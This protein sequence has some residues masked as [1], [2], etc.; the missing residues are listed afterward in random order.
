MLWTGVTPVGVEA[1]AGDR[2]GVELVPLLDGGSSR[3]K[4]P[5][6]G[7]SASGSV[8]PRAIPVGPTFAVVVDG[9]RSVWPVLVRIGGTPET[10]RSPV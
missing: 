10:G 9:R 6:R 4:E 3:L 8:T 2:V 1:S 5:R 7:W